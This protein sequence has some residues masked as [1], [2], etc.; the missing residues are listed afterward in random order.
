MSETEVNKAQ[1]EMKMQGL[2]IDDLGN[3]DGENDFLE[4]IQH[5]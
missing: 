5:K 3:D 4:N 2:K 1:A